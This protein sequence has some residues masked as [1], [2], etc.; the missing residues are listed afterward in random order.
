MMNSFRTR[1]LLVILLH[2]RVTRPTS[3]SVVV[4]AVATVPAAA[5]PADCVSSSSSEQATNAD[6][7]CFTLPQPHE[8]MGS[9]MIGL[10]FEMAHDDRLK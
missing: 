5:Q 2:V 6:L 7:T 4:A 10:A 8:P 3:F 9:M 1:L